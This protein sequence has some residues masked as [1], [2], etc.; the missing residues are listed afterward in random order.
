MAVGANLSFARGICLGLRVYSR[1]QRP[2][3]SDRVRSLDGI[4]RS[5]CDL[6]AGQEA[7]MMNFLGGAAIGFII[8]FVVACFVLFKI[9]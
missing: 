8:G 1:V 6:R 3:S 9:W 4:G 2:V 7:E 5:W